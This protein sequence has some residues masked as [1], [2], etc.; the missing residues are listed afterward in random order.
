MCKH[1]FILTSYSRICTQCGIE[2][3]MLNL[4]V[5]NKFSAPLCKGYERS[6]RFRQKTDK[7]LYLM[8]PPPFESPIWMHLRKQNMSNPQ[9]VRDALRIYTGKQKHYDCVRI[10]TRTFT[11]FRAESSHDNVFL[12][13]R[14]QELFA[15]ILRN[16]ATHDTPFFSY[17]FL[18]RLFLA[19]MKS[20][21]EAF[22]KPITCIR[23]HQRNL[24]RIRSILAPGNGGKLSHTPEGD[25]SRYGK[26]RS[27]YPPCPPTW[28]ASVLAE[29]VGLDD[30]VRGK[31]VAGH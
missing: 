31:A 3:T 25:H 1:D 20:P 10:F 27:D 21:L 29:A 18:L 23:R 19:I 28:A 6:V 8:N 7:L 15:C 9:G 26:Y 11:P 13:K 16:W 14:L 5:Y 4:D 2:K 17:D 24:D 12:H 22:C 30:Y